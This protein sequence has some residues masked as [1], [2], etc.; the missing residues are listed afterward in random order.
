M[1]LS[2]AHVKSALLT[3]TSSKFQDPPPPPRPTQHSAS[4]RTCR[5]CS[6]T[7][8]AHAGP[9]LFSKMPTPVPPG[10][11]LS[12]ARSLGAQLCITKAPAEVLESAVRSWHGCGNGHNLFIA[13]GRATEPKK[14]NTHR[15]DGNTRRDGLMCWKKTPEKLIRKPIISAVF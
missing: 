2:N 9:N 15:S 7:S 1:L 6:K 14:A 4:M 11:R 10:L 8:E 12:S 13:P 3:S 5:E